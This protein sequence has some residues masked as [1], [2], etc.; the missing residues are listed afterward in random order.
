MKCKTILSYEVS[1]NGLVA[2]RTS[3]G[4]LE[5]LITSPLIEMMALES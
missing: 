5:I 3:I 2:V 4:P 1:K